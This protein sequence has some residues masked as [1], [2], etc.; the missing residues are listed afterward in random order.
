[1]TTPAENADPLRFPAAAVYL[2]YAFVTSMA[3]MKPSVRIA[4]TSED[5]LLYEAR[6]L[7]VAPGLEA[8]AQVGPLIDGIPMHLQLGQSSHGVVDRPRSGRVVAAPDRPQGSGENNA[9]DSLPHERKPNGRF[10]GCEQN[11]SAGHG[12]HCRERTQLS[13]ESPPTSRNAIG[14]PA[15]ET[16]RDKVAHSQQL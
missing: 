13:W 16:T 7:K 2:W 4:G 1:M 10:R 15:L 9:D 8:G 5:E 14:Q 6:S 11:A 12:V 3:F